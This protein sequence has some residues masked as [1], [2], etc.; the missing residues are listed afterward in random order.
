MSM[1][2]QT[3]SLNVAT[4]IATVAM[5]LAMTTSTMTKQTLHS[6]IQSIATQMRPSCYNIGYNDSRQSWEVN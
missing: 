2:T 5:V 1:D 3:F 4:M 6:K